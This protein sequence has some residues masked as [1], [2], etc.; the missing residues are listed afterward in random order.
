[1]FERAL[2]V[3]VTVCHRLEISRSELTERP[4]CRQ[5]GI[6]VYTELHWHFAPERRFIIFSDFA[7]LGVYS[8]LKAYN[9]SPMVYGK[10]PFRQEFIYFYAVICLFY[11]RA[12]E[13][14]DFMNVDR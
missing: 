10:H 14:Y 8:G 7:L 2:L 4:D 3:S 11:N 9:S 13:Y 1:V 6:C 12:R 5:T